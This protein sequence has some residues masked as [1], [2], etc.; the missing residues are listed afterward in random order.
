MGLKLLTI[1]GLRAPAYIDAVTAGAPAALAGLRKDDLI[2]KVGADFIAD[3]KAYQDV[4]ARLAP[5][6]PVTILVKRNIEGQDQVVAAVVTP[7]EARLPLRPMPRPAT[8]GA[9]TP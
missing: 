1:A 9:S 6:A 8:T 3:C 4:A 7:I 2:L 5:G